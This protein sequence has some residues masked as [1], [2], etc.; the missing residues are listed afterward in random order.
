MAYLR[1]TV[2]YDIAA[3]SEPKYPTLLFSI[4]NRSGA[5]YCSITFIIVFFLV[6]D[7]GHTDYPAG[8]ECAER[9]PSAARGR[10]SSRYW[11]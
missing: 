6:E 1:F 4:V 10:S 7:T 2:K 5:L 11:R 8:Q 9:K 3:H